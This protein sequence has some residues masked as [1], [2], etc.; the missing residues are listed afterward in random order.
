ML[1]S[2]FAG[3]Q[4]LLLAENDEELVASF[5]EKLNMKD[6]CYMLAEAWDSLE[7]QRL[8]NA[9]SKLWPNLEGE[10]DFNDDPREEIIDFVQSIPGFQECDE[11]DV[12]IWMARDAEDF[13]FQ[14]LNYDEIVTSMQEESDPVDGET[15]EDEDNN[16]NS[17]GPSNAD[18]FSALETAMV[19]Y[20]QQSMFCP[21]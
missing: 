19:W 11:D 18:A 12:E 3:D 5:A 9:W 16:E 13:G 1:N 2:C 21:T 15:D 10:K 7:R 20:E 17:K 8:K 6:T 4:K 14:M